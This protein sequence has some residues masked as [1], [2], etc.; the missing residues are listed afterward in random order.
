MFYC[1]YYHLSVQ[2]PGWPWWSRPPLC[3][4]S[5]HLQRPTRWSQHQLTQQNLL[6]R[7]DGLHRTVYSHCNYLKLLK[8]CLCRSGHI[9]NISARLFN[10]L[11]F[12]QK[13]YYK[14]SIIC[15]FILYH[16]NFLYI[17]ISGYFL[18]YKLMI[19]LLFGNF[20]F[21]ALVCKSI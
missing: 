8:H 10:L 15:W 16:N 6:Q 18:I 4:P 20:S 1:L 12:Y 14:K 2:V 3:S 17:Y 19:C 13:S 5:P 7:D 9:S 21:S 11:Y